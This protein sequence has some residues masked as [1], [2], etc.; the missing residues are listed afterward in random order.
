M[1]LSFAA[2]AE[3]KTEKT[4]DLSL[5]S[6][7]E[8]VQMAVQNLPSAV[9][10]RNADASDN[11][12]LKEIQVVGPV[13]FLRYEGA[14]GKHSVRIEI[15]PIPSETGE[16]QYTAELSRAC[17]NLMEAAKIRIKLIEKLERMGILVHADNLKTRMIL[18][19][20]E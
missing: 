6:P 7:S 1:T 15:W 5:L 11:E 18:K 14:L 8:A 9:K 4:P 12:R 16:I 3:V 2:N 19:P 13:R 20:A 17:K 10:D